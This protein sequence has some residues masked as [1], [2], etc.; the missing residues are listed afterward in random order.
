MHDSK[1]IKRHFL[2]NLIIVCMY[3]QIISFSF[4]PSSAIV[5]ETSEM[6][7]FGEIRNNESGNH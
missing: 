6:A 1:M 5:L 2:E 7:T 3:F 4:S